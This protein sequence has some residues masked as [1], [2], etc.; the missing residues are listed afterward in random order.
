MLKSIGR[1]RDYAPLFLR[2]M[3]GTTLVF[4][5]GLPKLLSPNRWERTGQAM[6]ALGITFAP[7]FW[8]FMAAICEVLGGVLFWIGLAVRPTAVV[9]IWMMF[10]AIARQVAAEGFGGLEGSNAHPLDFASGTL[11]LLILGAGAYSLDRKL[12]L[13]GPREAQQPPEPRRMAV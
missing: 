11:A 12:G 7:V 3:L 2:L 1:Y 9:V 5:H 4:S 10:V 8:G 6:A 13:E